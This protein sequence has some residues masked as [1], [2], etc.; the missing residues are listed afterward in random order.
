MAKNQRL[1]VATLFAPPTSREIGIRAGAV[2]A[3]SA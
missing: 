3:I 2:R 1:R